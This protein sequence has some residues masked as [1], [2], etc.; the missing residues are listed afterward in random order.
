ME[1]LLHPGVSSTLMS[2]AELPEGVAS[3][4][5]GA[6]FK[7]ASLDMTLSILTESAAQMSGVERVSIWALTHEHDELRCLE[8]FER[9]QKRHSSGGAMQAADYP[10]YFDALRRESCVAADDLFTNPS[11]QGF[12]A[13]YLALHGVTALLATPIHIRGELQG[14]LCLEQV[15]PRLP[16]TPSHQLFAHAVANLVTLALVEFEVGQAKQQ[17]QSATERLR[18]VFDASR[19]AML[20]ADAV[21]G[22]ILDANRQAEK[23]FA[24]PRRQLIGKHRK[25]LHPAGFAE[26]GGDQCLMMAADQ[27]AALHCCEIQRLDGSIQKVEVSAEL[28]EISD[29]RKLLLGVLRPV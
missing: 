18:A 2:P 8:L 19:D 7:E 1:N 17:A 12:A 10:A 25:A 9:S 16:W 11:T 26:A 4:S 24:C 6:Y 14:V 23:L 20:L 27:S 29:G 21:S 28:A 5:R 13:D 3:L 22:I 15:G